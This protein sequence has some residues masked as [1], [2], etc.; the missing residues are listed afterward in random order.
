MTAA[1]TSLG[2]SL[3]AALLGGALLVACLNTPGP[4]LHQPNPFVDRQFFTVP[5]S[6]EGGGGGT[7][8]LANMLF[9]SPAAPG[10]DADLPLPRVIQLERY[11]LTL[12]WTCLQHHLSENIQDGTNTRVAVGLQEYLKMEAE[13]DLKI[14]AH[15]DGM[16]TWQCA[17]AEWTEDAALDDFL[18]ALDLAGADGWQAATARSPAPPGCEQA[19]EVR[20]F[21]GH[22][23]LVIAQ[24]LNYTARSR[25]RASARATSTPGG[26]K[27]WVPTLQAS[28]EAKSE[29]DVLQQLG[30]AILAADVQAWEL[31][32][33]RIWLIPGGKTPAA[34]FVL[35]GMPC[36]LLPKPG[37]LRD[38]VWLSPSSRLGG[39]TLVDVAA[40]PQ[41]PLMVTR[42]QIGCQPKCPKKAN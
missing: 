15:L 30:P 37:V 5:F 7:N 40:S 14:E 3:M 39:S 34:E 26:G 23:H 1:P 18:L 2:R 9:I 31:R 16:D 33:E 13:T 42:W 20:R 28:A 4:R 25:E 6:V 22:A 19:V 27:I 29:W 12:R 17:G 21:Y 35:M 24:R 41:F 36:R 8:M 38:G 32:R 11:G 10:S